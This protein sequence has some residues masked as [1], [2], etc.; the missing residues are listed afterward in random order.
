LAAYQKW[1]EQMLSHLE[2]MFS[3]MI[4]HIN[5]GYFWGARDPF[6]IKP[7]YYSIS[8]HMLRF[9]SEPAALW[10]TEPDKPQ[11]DTETVA[12]FLMFGLTDHTERTFFT[13]I[14]Q[15][16]GGHSITGKVGSRRSF[17]IKPWWKPSPVHIGEK[18]EQQVYDCI[19]ESVG[20]HLRSD[21]PV[22]GCLSGG[23]DS[24]SINHFAAEIAK[25]EHSVFNS[26]TFSEKGFEDDESDLALAT[27]SQT[28]TK[29][30]L[31]HT[32]PQELEKELDQL[33]LAMGE[34]YNTLSM[35]AQF[36]VFK[37]A[38]ELGLKVMLDGQGGDEVFAGYPRVAALVFKDYLKQLSFKRA[39]NELRGFRQNANVGFKEFLGLN[40]LFTNSQL[41]ERRSMKRLSALV[42][43]DLLNQY[44]KSVSTEYFGNKTFAQAQRMELTKY[45]IP[46]LLRYEDRN[47]MHFSIESRVPLL[48]TKV[49]NL[50]LSLP[51]DANVKKGWTKY[52]LRKAMSTHLPY[53]VVW[54]RKKRGFDV[55]QEK[56]MKALSPYLKNLLK[57]SASN[58][59]ALDN[60]RLIK[61]IDQH[62]NQG[63]IWRLVSLQLW[64][65]KNGLSISR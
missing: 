24:G 31:I 45:I 63:H 51:A 56:W 59:P 30:H 19:K 46:R 47:S 17:Q 58:N 21:V 5:T 20:I 43:E 3:F 53:E 12:D 42:S 35:Y 10:K 50:G 39:F 14:K 29:L 4:Y 13:D 22:G 64:L 37:K 40:Y 6:G 57:E 49:V 25:Q 18:P 7:F 33:T 62:S 60:E 23:I 32:D 38:N 55:P 2:G 28:G 54:Q 16:R 65:L 26:I 1:G 48:S 41:M 8:D 44:D 9:A 36:R 61:N 52:S 11:V 27:S 34:P 15:L